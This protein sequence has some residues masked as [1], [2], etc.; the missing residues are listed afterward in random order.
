MSSTDKQPL[1]MQMCEAC[2]PNAPLVNP[3]EQVELLA[4]LNDWQIITVQNVQQLSKQYAFNNF[5]EAQAFSNLVGG[6][7]EEVGHHPA[8]LTE[9]GKVTVRWWSHKIAGLH[10]NDFVMAARTDLIR[11]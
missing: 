3:E 6:L 1:G 11:K 2:Q 9:W 7:A 5:V 4:E 8:I 10:K